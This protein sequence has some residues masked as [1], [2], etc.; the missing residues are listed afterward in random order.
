MTF[1]FC[2]D[3]VGLSE[4]KFS[5]DRF[6]R[7]NWDS[8]IVGKGNFKGSKFGISA[9]AYPNID[10]INLEWPQAKQIYFEDYWQKYRISE[11]N[12]PI[13]LYVLDSVINHGGDGI[14]LLQRASGAKIDGRVGPNTLTLSYK[15]E[16][17]DF[18][19]VRGD[20]YV[21]ITQN[22]F[23]DDN[24]RKQLKGWVRRNTIVFATTLKWVYDNRGNS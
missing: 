15:C 7:G 9:M 12:A 6:D 16:P 17:L 4:G 19:L 21:Q 23:N 14:K 24:D 8:G 2:I 5:T 18:A 1:D 13:R 11:M 20:H 3:H 22:G 10:I